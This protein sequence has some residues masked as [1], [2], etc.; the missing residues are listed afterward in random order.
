M[1]L[2]ATDHPLGKDG[3]FSHADEARILRILRKYKGTIRWGG[4]YSG[5]QDEMHFEINQPI[6]VCER[7]AKEL[8]ASTRGEMVIEANKGLLKEIY[9]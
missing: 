8:V 3:T 5:R 4:T 7:V 6:T 2:N 9:S 1:D